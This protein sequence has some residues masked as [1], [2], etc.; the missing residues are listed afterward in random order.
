[1]ASTEKLQVLINATNNTRKAFQNAQSQMQG[2]QD[3]ARKVGRSM[4]RVGSKMT[5]FVSVPLAGAAGA[6]VKFS[7]DFNSKMSEVQ[8]TADLTSE[9][10]GKIGE[11]VEDI[12]VDTGQATDD[13][14]DGFQ[15]AMSGSLNLTESQ[16]L[17]NEATRASASGFGDLEKIVDVSTT[18]TDLYADSVDSATGALNKIVN[19]AANTQVEVQNLVGAFSRGSSLAAEL[20][21]S[22]D[23]FGSILG[24]VSER[25]GDTQRGGRAVA[26]MLRTLQDPSKSAKK[27]LQKAGT[28]AE[29][30]KSDLE[31]DAI[32]ALEDLRTQLNETGQGIEDVISSGN[33]LN[34][35]QVL[36]SDSGERATE[37]LEGQAD[38]AG[39]VDE[40]Y[41]K[42]ESFSRD[43]AEAMNAVKKAG[44]ALGDVLI[45]E[46]EGPLNSLADTL[47]SAADAFESAS[48]ATQK[49]IVYIGAVVAAIGPLLVV[50]GTLSVAIAALSTPVLAVAVAIGTVIALFIAFKKH[51]EGAMATVKNLATILKRKLETSW[52]KVKLIWSKITSYIIRKLNA[53]AKNIKA[54]LKQYLNY[55]SSIFTSIW[56]FVQNIFQ[57][58]KA[59]IVS[60]VSAIVNKFNAWVESVKSLISAFSDL[61]DEIQDFLD[62][63]DDLPDW[64]V[65]GI[66][67][68]LPDFFDISGSF[69][70]GGVVPGPIGQP[71]L[72][73]VHAGETILPTHKKRMASGGSNINITING[74]VSGR[75]VIEK[76]KRGIK[77]DLKR[78]T[79]L[80]TR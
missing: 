30:L 18:A 21:I 41:Q 17:V 36:L 28:S 12:A 54:G 56:K 77:E 24:V 80:S 19:I 47:S 7:T 53:I 8:S 50:L 42:S 78:E 72:A 14:F 3:K 43:L 74:D 40:A 23:Q 38:A 73:K 37:V 60:G 20:G 22:I 76:V 52:M 68:A 11:S 32:A 10:I 49:F 63:S 58:I 57:R 69:D 1:M 15:K 67:G 27:A 9:E 31:D 64:A 62:V 13:I 16:E 39:S 66:G 44:R 71:R 55:W 45:D 33:A 59:T 65:E 5:R 46:L 48:P 79:K 26:S 61:I 70:S 34:A 75:E 2:L 6:A 4:Q 25:F 51:G 29:E 35:A